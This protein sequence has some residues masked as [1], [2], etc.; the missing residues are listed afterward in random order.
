M[1]SLVCVVKYILVV[2]IS[3]NAPKSSENTHFWRLIHCK[4]ML[5]YVWYMFNKILFE[6]FKYVSTHKGSFRNCGEET[7]KLVPLSVCVCVCVCYVLA[8]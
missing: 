4:E 5:D 7:F 2:K 8:S 3:C 6:C 1:E